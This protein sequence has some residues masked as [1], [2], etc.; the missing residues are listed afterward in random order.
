MLGIIVRSDYNDGHPQSTALKL[1]I[2]LKAGDS[3]QFGVDD[4][5]AMIL[6]RLVHQ[7]R[8]T[9]L[10]GAHLETGRG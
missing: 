8:F 3:G 5:T 9:R 10:E 2:E 4:Q 7:Q 1:S 6:Q